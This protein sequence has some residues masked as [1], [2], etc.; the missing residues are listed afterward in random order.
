MRTIHQTLFALSLVI[1]S[2]ANASHALDTSTQAVKAEPNGPLYVA[3]TAESTK[4]DLILNNTLLVDTIE[5]ALNEFN[6]PGM[7][8][9]VVYQGE[10]LLINGFGKAN[11]NKNIDATAD[12]YFRLASVSKAFTSAALAI[13]VDQGKLSWDDKVI[14][15]LP[16]F[17]MHD[18][19]V[20][21]EFTVTDLLTHRSGLVSGAGDSMIW[22]E[23]SGFSRDEVIHNLRYLKPEYSFRARYAY[24]NVLYITAGELVAKLSGQ[25][26]DDFVNEHIFTALEMP[27]FAGDMPSTAVKNSA[28]AYGHSDERG[29]YPVTRNNISETGLMSAAAG[30]MVCNAK[31]M[32]KWLHALLSQENLPFSKQQLNKMLSPE[33]ILGISSIEK[34]W[35]N[36]QFKSYGL[37]WR[38]SNLGHLKMVSHTGTLS[39][40]QAYIALLPELEF[41]VAI[42]NNGSNSAARGAVMQTLIKGLLEY[43]EIDIRHAQAQ[44][45]QSSSDWVDNYIEY[46]NEREQRYLTNYVS[47]KAISDMSIANETIVGEYRD[48]WFGSM[49]IVKENGILRISSSRMTTLKGTVLPFQDFSFKVEWDNKNAASDAFIHFTVNVN[50]EVT[51]ARMHPFTVAERVNHAYKDMEFIKVVSEEE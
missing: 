3:S 25:S 1:T 13:L 43:K 36:T 28:M 23:P 10:S 41:G 17:T 18:P 19:Y 40:Y 16:N 37:G 2:M 32:S 38:L 12:T 8:V 30:G 42:L 49:H 45:E 33:T 14:Q 7:A 31:G 20:T 21:R 35:D 9:S 51:S 29:I 39:G 50:R 44:I 5:R 26:F 34:E 15:H 11:I 27:C 6:T 47:P 24:S 4:G 46:L 22:P 48:K